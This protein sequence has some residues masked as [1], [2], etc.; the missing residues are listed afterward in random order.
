MMKV[1]TFNLIRPLRS[2]SN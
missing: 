1:V 2:I